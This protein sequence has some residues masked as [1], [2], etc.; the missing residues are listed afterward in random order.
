MPPWLSDLECTSDVLKAWSPLRQQSIELLEEHREAQ[1]LA[2]VDELS[3]KAAALILEHRDRAQEL[4]GHFWGDRQDPHPWPFKHYCIL[5]HVT[6]FYLLAWEASIEA[7]LAQAEH[8]LTSGIAMLRMDD[9]DLFEH[10][11]WPFTSFDILSNLFFIRRGWPFQ[12]KHLKPMDAGEWIRQRLP[13]MWPPYSPGCWPRC[14]EETTSKPRLNFWWMSKNPGPFVDLATILENWMS[15][16]YEVQVS[17]NALADH[18]EYARY[19]DWLCSKND[20][21]KEVLEEQRIVTQAS[22]VDCGERRGQWCGLRELHQE[23]DEK[24]IPRFQAQF[25]ELRQ[26]DL[27]AC[28]HPLYWC[29]LLA[30]FGTPI[31]GIWDMTHNFAVPEHLQEHWTR[32]FLDLFQKRENLLV[33]MSAY[34]SFQVRWLLGLRVPYFQ[35]VT[36]DVSLGAKYAPDLRPHEVLVSKFH[37]PYE[38]ELLHR[39]AEAVPSLPFRFVAWQDLPC[40]QDCSKAELGSFRASVLSAYDTSPMKLTEFYA[41]SIPICIFSGG[42]WRTAMRWA[43]ADAVS[44]GLNA[45]LAGHHGRD[46]APGKDWSKDGQ[47][48]HRALTKETEELRWDRPWHPKPLALGSP[49]SQGPPHMDLPFSPFMEDRAQ[50]VSPGAAFWVQLTDWALLP[51]LLRYESVPH[52]LQILSELSLDDLLEISRKMAGHYAKLLVA[53]TNFWRAVVMSM[54]EDHDASKWKG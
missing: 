22:Q 24:V 35:P 3:R 23:F 29:R 34:H 49:E 2:E 20:L 26:V 14:P 10:S 18:C 31:L 42:L 19:K 9:H 12:A 4:Y 37:T 8:Y 28:G 45:S 50:L 36:P 38:G 43:K 48:I 39:F 27:F 52:L 15:E 16:R 13:L 32:D 7:E 21:F 53:S 40:G 54:V 44:G 33:A 51:H 6:A 11:S 17:H 30:D 46:F 5:G 25:P 47:W 41:L 1:R